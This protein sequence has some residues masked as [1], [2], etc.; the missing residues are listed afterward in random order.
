[1][2]FCNIKDIFDVICNSQGT[3]LD[4]M[5]ASDVQGEPPSSGTCNTSH[6]HATDDVGEMHHDIAKVLDYS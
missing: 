3:P 1:M 4:N 6:V 2:L 5:H